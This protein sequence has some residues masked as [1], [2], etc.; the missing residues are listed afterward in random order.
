MYVYF[1]VDVFHQI[2]SIPRALPP[3]PPSKLSAKQRERK[4]AK[5][6]KPTILVHFH[7]HG[8]VCLVL[9]HISYIITFKILISYLIPHDRILCLPCFRL[10][11]CR[12]P[13]L[14][15]LWA[16]RLIQNDWFSRNSPKS[17]GPIRRWRWRAELKFWIATWLWT[18]T[19]CEI[20]TTEQLPWTDYVKNGNERHTFRCDI[21]WTITSRLS[22]WEE[23]PEEWYFIR[24]GYGKQPSRFR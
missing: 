12:H 17:N 11:S 10:Q 7:I 22:K 2:K 8:M 3:P 14:T 5:K 16:A 21:F 23:R 15:S 20:W 18:Y 1:C 24:G 9:F 19:M 6:K 4:K 13:S